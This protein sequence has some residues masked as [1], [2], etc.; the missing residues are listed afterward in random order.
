MMKVRKLRLKLKEYLNKSNI[1]Y[2]EEVANKSG[3]DLIKTKDNMTRA[4]KKLGVSFKDYHCENDF[5]KM[6]FDEQKE[7]YEINAEEREKRKE[8]RAMPKSML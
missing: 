1:K 5:Y 2:C 3:Q 8:E 4:Q 7:V 6:S